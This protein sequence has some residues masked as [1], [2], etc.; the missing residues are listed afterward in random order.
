MWLNRI[1]EPMIISGKLKVC[2][3]ANARKY[4]CTGAQRHHPYRLGQL[5]QV[6]IDCTHEDL[7]IRP[8]AASTADR[9]FDF[10]PALIVTEHS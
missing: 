7:G 10:R 6:V 4:F 1:I 2:K 8:S 5:L 3:T 9:Q